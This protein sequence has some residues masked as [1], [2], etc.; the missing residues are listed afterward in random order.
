M[1]T[2]ETVN[3][4]IGISQMKFSPVRNN[5]HE[6]LS[7][8]AL[9]DLLWDYRS[10]TEPHKHELLCYSLLDAARIGDDNFLEIEFQE[11]KQAALNLLQPK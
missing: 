3:L 1:L 5:R 6:N 10:I 9:H 8:L 11:L 4:I 7:C 2:D